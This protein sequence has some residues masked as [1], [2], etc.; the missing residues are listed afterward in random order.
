[1]LSCLRIDYRVISIR[2]DSELRPDMRPICQET[3]KVDLELVDV[4][5]V[6][7]VNDIGSGEPLFSA[8]QF[9]AGCKER[10]ETGQLGCFDSPGSDQRHIFLTTRG[11]RKPW[12]WN[13]CHLSSSR[14]PRYIPPRKQN[15]ARRKPA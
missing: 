8:F 2:L 3:P 15:P 1:M 10:V 11:G 14:T 13:K 12:P 4:F 5:G 9:E 6:D 7:D